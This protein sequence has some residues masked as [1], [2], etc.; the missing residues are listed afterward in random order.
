MLDHLAHAFK[1][2]PVF[3]LVG[4]KDQAIRPT[5][6][7]DVVRILAAA[8]L[9]GRL[10][11][12]TVAVV[13][14]E[15]MTL[16]EAVTRVARAVGKVPPMIRLLIW[17]HWF[18]ASS[19]ELTMKIPLLARAQLRILSEGITDVLPYAE[20]L[21]EDLEPRISFTQDQITKGLPTL[22]AFSLKDL[23]WI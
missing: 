6:V 17:V 11:R 8:L 7:E 22:K 20:P 12:T 10:P 3:A 13:G 23:R 2:F 15:I 9:E 14:P 18:L 19:F 4:M 1:T 16:K 5:A 21:P